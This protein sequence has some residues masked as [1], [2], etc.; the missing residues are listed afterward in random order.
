VVVVVVE[1]FIFPIGS[2]LFDYDHDDDN[3]SD[4]DS[5]PMGMIK[6]ILSLAEAL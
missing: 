5:I 6:P 4:N 1:L 3:D 2:H